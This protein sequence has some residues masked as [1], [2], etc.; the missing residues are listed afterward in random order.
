[1]D[2]E[3]TEE[4][5][6]L[7]QAGR[8]S[9]A[10]W[11]E[12]TTGGKV[13]IVFVVLLLLGLVF[14]ALEAVGLYTPDEDRGRSTTDV[15]SFEAEYACNDF[16][17]DRLKSPSTAHFNEDTSS[18]VGNRWT[19]SGSVDSENSFGA[20]LRSTFTCTMTISGDTWRLVDLDFRDGGGVN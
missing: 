17:R 5:S 19:V 12:S 3:P 1:M 7:V 15:G 16:A 4:P 2:S 8:A 6:K 14:W 9:A 11:R 10:A 18:N 13:V 20:S